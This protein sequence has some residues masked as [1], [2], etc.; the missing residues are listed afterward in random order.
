MSQVTD[1]E[2]YN[3]LEQKFNMACS[4]L[5]SLNSN[6]ASTQ[7]RYD[8]AS[9]VNRRSYRYTLR[10]RLVVMEGVRNMYYHYAMQK[11][12]ELEQ[13]KEQIEDTLSESE[14]DMENWDHQQSFQKM[15]LFRANQWSFS[16]PNTSS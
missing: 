11:A 12:E 5:K 9:Q 8:R 1:Y 15:V 7:T 14:E 16:G 10:I 3:A 2:A 13:A 4:C 6:I